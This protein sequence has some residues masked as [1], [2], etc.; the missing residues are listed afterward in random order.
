MFLGQNVR[1]AKATALMVAALLLCYTPLIGWSI[2][3][4]MGMNKFN[5]QHM[6]FQ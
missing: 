6:L 1:A 2:T 5:L 3:M 4:L